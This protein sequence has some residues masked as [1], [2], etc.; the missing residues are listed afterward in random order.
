MD[1]GH[2]SLQ[3]HEVLQQGLLTP[4]FQ[5]IVDMNS[6]ALIGYEGLIRG[7]EGSALHAPAQLFH[8]ARQSGLGPQ[9]ED[10][11]SEVIL[12]KFVELALPG[13]IF[14]NISPDSLIKAGVTIADKL[15][16]LHLIGVAPQR[17]I[18]EMTENQAI[19]D[20][21]AM[22][23]VLRRCRSLGIQIAIDDLG[24]GFSSL[25]LWS[26]IR[27]DYVKIDM[28]FI[29]GIDRDPVKLQFVQS[30][31]QIARKSGTVTI[32][33]G[34]ETD[35]ELRLLQE[36]GIGWGQGYRIARPLAQPALAITAELVARIRH[37]AALAT[38]GNQR[39]FN[40]PTALKLLRIVPVATPDTS[41]NAVYTTFAADA[42]LE[43][44]P[45]V[46]NGVPLGIINRFQFID[47]LARP[48]QRELYG[49]RSCTAFMTPEPLTVD[50]NTSLQD[51]SLMIVEAKSHH[52][53]NGF[54]ITD[55]GQYIGVG[56]SQDV[57]RE[58]TQMQINAARY[59]NPLTQLP[60]NVPINEEIDRRLAAG[61]EFNVCYGD[62]D[63]FKPFNDVYGY[64]RGDDIIR[65][66]GDILA[67]YC[68]P[69]VDFLGHVGGDD[70][71]I[72]FQSADWKCRCDGILE[73]FAAETP[74]FFSAADRSNGGYVSEDRRGNRVFHPL[75]SLS[76]GVVKIDA[77][78]H[79]SSYQIAAAA[80]DAKKQAKTMSG[81]S[82]F[83]E[84][85]EL[86]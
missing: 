62:I 24:E 7:P 75:V 86:Q 71:I 29:Q 11:C 63:H 56:S 5:P 27:P 10:C 1:G 38:A 36:L 57:M 80:A 85:R 3:L 26:E 19:H 53:S 12:K 34:I 43:V 50:K 17:I 25:R 20:Y 23:E 59:A 54:T 32:A 84:R 66:T 76:L 39:G 72:L 4:V 78:R 21:D 44:M 69:G 8:A 74:A 64:L 79:Y 14:L 61:V 49:K 46:R 47:R 73:T 65:L 13:R 30:I 15:A 31:Q 70:F 83:L 77:A 37:N 60:G 28:H 55:H 35:T 22:R 42:G 18:L 81:N 52:F 33:E 41:T 48:Y 68:V 2:A 45:V 40:L 16:Q 67:R 82:L 9:L 58:I 51:I 6:G